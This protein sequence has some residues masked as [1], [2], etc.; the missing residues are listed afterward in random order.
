MVSHSSGWSIPSPRLIFVGVYIFK[1]DLEELKREKEG[2]SHLYAEL[3]LYIENSWLTYD[4]AEVHPQQNQT[5]VDPTIK[6][7]GSIDNQLP[8]T[9]PTLP[10]VEKK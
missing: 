9:G 4:S 2:A 6:S 7:A 10:G 1:P 3:V 5:V 8:A